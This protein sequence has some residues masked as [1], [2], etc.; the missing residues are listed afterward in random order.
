[1][2]ALVVLSTYLSQFIPDDIY[3]LYSFILLKIHFQV[4]ILTAICPTKMSS[5]LALSKMQIKKKYCFIPSTIAL[6]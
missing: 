2:L 1:M 4:H 6:K 3:G 5:G